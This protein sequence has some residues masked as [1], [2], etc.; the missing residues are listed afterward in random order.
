M[1]D[2]GLA[3]WDIFNSPLVLTI[4]SLLWG[5]LVAS[6][7]AEL[8]QRRARRQ[9]LRAQQT[10]DMLSVYHRYVRLLRGNPS[11]L[12]GPRFDD[13]HAQFLSLNKLNL[14]LFRT[15]QIYDDWAH[16]ATTLTAAR[17]RLMKGDT[18]HWRALFDEIRPTAEAA[19]T[20]MFREIF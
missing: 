5:A 14:L 2:T 6:T 12:D 11:Q 10:K 9:Q 8:W 3:I 15:H 17:G 18:C 20:T 7:I 1:P 4:L 19:T 13:I 16:V